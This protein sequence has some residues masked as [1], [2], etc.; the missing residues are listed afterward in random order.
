MCPHFARLKSFHKELLYWRAVFMSTLTP[1]RGD[2]FILCRTLTRRALV[3]ITWL[4]TVTTSWPAAA[5][6]TPNFRRSGS[7]NG[8]ARTPGPG[9][10]VGVLTVR[11]LRHGSDGN[12]GGGGEGRTRSYHFHLF[13]KAKQGGRRANGTLARTHAPA[14]VVFCLLCCSERRHDAWHGASASH[15]RHLVNGH[16]VAAVAVA[17]ACAIFRTDAGAA[18]GV[19][20]L[21]KAGNYGE[22]RV[23]GDGGGCASACRVNV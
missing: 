4:G 18:R 15:T 21:Y 19:H 7:T 23:S 12:G 22:W 8:R 5:A 16:R 13:K 17:V 10:R 1:H 14:R 6:D 11:D 20:K 2:H 9:G 3:A